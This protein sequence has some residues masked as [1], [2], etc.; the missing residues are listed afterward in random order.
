MGSTE[1]TMRMVGS[2]RVGGGGAGC[3]L[4][5]L[6]SLFRGEQ[7]S[8]LT[9]Q[10][11]RKKKKKKREKS[12]AKS[13]GTKH[14]QTVFVLERRG[15]RNE[16]GQTWR[17]K[18]RGW[19]GRRRKV[20]SSSEQWIGE[21]PRSHWRGTGSARRHL[22]VVVSEVKAKNKTNPQPAQDQVSQPE[23]HRRTSLHMFDM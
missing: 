4:C 7:T 5:F 13:S 16:V 15:V 20:S 22:A 19:E 8:S 1:T 18:R 9:A 10:R 3:C 21:S 11:R 12:K 23:Q 14:R 6:Q 17:K 2:A